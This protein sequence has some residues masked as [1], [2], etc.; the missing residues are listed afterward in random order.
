MLLPQPGCPATVPHPNLGRRQT[1]DCSLGG[2]TWNCLDLGTPGHWKVK[3]R[4]HIESRKLRVLVLNAEIPSL[5]LLSALRTYSLHIS[6]WGIFLW[7]NWPT[8]KRLSELNY[9]PPYGISVA[10]ILDGKDTSQEAYIS[11]KLCSALDPTA[12]SLRVFEKSH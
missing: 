11:R 8:Q 10:W 5:L 1:E 4:C 6:I 7:R 2:W 12:N 9:A 3:V